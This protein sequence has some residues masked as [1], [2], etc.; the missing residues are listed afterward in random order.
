MPGVDS[1]DASHAGALVV[2]PAVPLGVR[3]AEGQV[4][5][6]AVEFDGLLGMGPVSL[7]VRRAYTSDVYLMDVL[8]A[9]HA[10]FRVFPCS[11]SCRP[12]GFLDAL[13][14]D[15][16]DVSHTEGRGCLR[17]TPLSTTLMP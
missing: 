10:G 1:S 15:A 5:L 4:S 12:A 16:F 3:L 13:P 8:D 9:L 7:D 14:A 11:V 2:H 17:A 6:R